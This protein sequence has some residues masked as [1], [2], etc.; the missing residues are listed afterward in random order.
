[1]LRD[2]RLPRI[3][4]FSLSVVLTIMMYVVHSG[5][6][7]LAISYVLSDYVKIDKKIMSNEQP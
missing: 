6:T 3:F 2:V 4:R 7:Y 5:T 1:M